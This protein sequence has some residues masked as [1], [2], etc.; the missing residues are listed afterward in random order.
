VYVA[1]RMSRRLLLLT[2]LLLAP[3]CLVGEEVSPGTAE[4]DISPGV[5]LEQGDMDEFVVEGSRPPFVGDQRVD[6][7][8][9]PH[10]SVTDPCQCN[11]QACV[12]SW[13]D[14]NLGCNVCISLYCDGQPSGHICSQCAI[15][16]T[17]RD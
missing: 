3:A 9:W 11:S 2:A 13:V 4:V 8:Q 17:Y 7:Q 6:D 15:A 14:E 1:N 16:R 10:T 5:D 12:D